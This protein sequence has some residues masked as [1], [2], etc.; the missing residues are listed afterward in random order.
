MY[1]ELK[2]TKAN[3]DVV[4]LQRNI[5]SLA[6]VIDWS[7]VRQDGRTN[8]TGGLA[9][10]SS[11]AAVTCF[12]I[13]PQNYSVETVRSYTKLSQNSHWLSWHSTGNIPR[14]SQGTD[15]EP[16]CFLRLVLRTYSVV[17]LTRPIIVHR[18]IR[19]HSYGWHV[20]K[21]NKS[22]CFLQAAKRL[23]VI[24]VYMTNIRIEVYLPNVYLVTVMT[25]PQLVHVAFRCIA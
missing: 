4:Q 21:I 11:D 18:R 5:L 7:D 22:L 25:S 2:W 8:V 13:L 24:L 3:S 14:I 15:A 17:V 6:C 23:T 12:K 10:M 16:I 20:W 9:R 1:G 19:L